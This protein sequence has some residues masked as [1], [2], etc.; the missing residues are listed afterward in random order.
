M[1]HGIFTWP[2]LVIKMGSECWW[3][4][5]PAPWFASKRDIELICWITQWVE[6]NKGLTVLMDTPWDGNLPVQPGEAWFLNHPPF[7]RCLMPNCPSMFD[8]SSYSGRQF[9]FPM[10]GNL[11]RSKWAVFKAPGP[12]GW[13]VFRG[14]Y[15][16]VYW[17]LWF[18]IIQERV[19]SLQANQDYM[20]W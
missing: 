13:W 10:Y 20:E 19:Q 17:G 2:W 12:V 3:V 14:L 4:N 1:L 18:I 8:R 9:C 16:P 11:R 15:Y 6:I 7:L 5:I